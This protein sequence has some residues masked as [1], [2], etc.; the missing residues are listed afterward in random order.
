[1][2]PVLPGLGNLFLS[3]ALNHLSLLFE[4]LEKLKILPCRK[5]NFLSTIT[6]LSL[7]PPKLP[8]CSRK[9]WV[10][11]ISEFVDVED[12]ESGGVLKEQLLPLIITSQSVFLVP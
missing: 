9:S 2:T 12:D 8:F 3:L 5:L 11:L 6:V 7:P 4:V 10:K 1:M